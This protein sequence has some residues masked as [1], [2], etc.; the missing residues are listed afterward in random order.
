M[1]FKARVQKAMENHHAKLIKKPRAKRE[2][3]N[4]RPEKEV[5]KACTQ[6]LRANGFSV[7]VVESK[8]VYSAAAGR[9]LS[10][11]TDQGFADCVGV[12]GAT[13]IAVFI[14]F[15][16]PGKLAT[17]RPTQKHFLRDKIKFNAFA[18]VVDSVERLQM[19]FREFDLARRESFG[20][21]QEYLT[22]MIS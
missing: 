7:N 1:D 15:K 13:G 5:E 4:G 9:Y 11:Q 21:S 3:P 19:I 17:L 16:A 8:A 18:C 6:W 22:S 14:E 10:G 20:R 2:K 12:H